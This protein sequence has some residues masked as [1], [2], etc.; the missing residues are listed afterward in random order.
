MTFT[1]ADASLPALL[2]AL[3]ALDA[4]LDKAIAFATT[5]KI[6]DAVFMQARLAPDMFAFARH[7]QIVCDFGTKTSARLAGREPTNRPDTEANFA[8]LKTRIAAAIADVEKITPAQIEAHANATISFPVAGKIEK[9][10]AGDYLTSFALPNLYFHASM[11][12][13]ILRHNGVALS[14]NDFLLGVRDKMMA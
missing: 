10:T 11:A 2:Q 12:Y 8:E 6:E 4:I 9:L 13:A 7:V 1:L 3:Q 5:R 14:K